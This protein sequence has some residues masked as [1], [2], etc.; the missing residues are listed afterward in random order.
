MRLIRGLKSNIDS[1]DGVIATIGNFDGVH[2]G[3]QDIFSKLIHKSTELNRSSMVIAFEP[4]AKEFFLG[5]N[6]PPRLTNFRE[7]YCLLKDIGIDQFVCFPFNTSLANMQAE[8]FVED[9]LIDHLRVKDLIIGDNFK[10]GKDRKG[11]YQLLKNMSAQFD[12]KVANTDSFLVNKTR[13]SSSLI[14]EHLAEGGLDAAKELLG[15]NYSMRGRVIHGDKKGRTIGFPTANIP[16]KRKISPVNGVFAVK[17]II[18]NK[19]EKFAVANIGHRPTVNGTRTQIEAN[20]FDF[21]ENIYGKHLEICF[22]KKIRDEKKFESFDA[23]KEQ[24]HKDT[25]SAKD[26]FNL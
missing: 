17:I 4:T 7:K 24:I 18:E 11:D 19:T 2:L 3:H 8:K 22:H 21:S 26:F 16:I 20:I 5:K 25:V 15:R 12:F 10:F 6:A 23:L 13:V 9:I 1:Q 14:R